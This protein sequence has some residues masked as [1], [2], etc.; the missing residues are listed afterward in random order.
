MDRIRRDSELIIRLQQWRSP[1]RDGFFRVVSLF[2]DEP[3]FTLG[4]PII[5]WSV[6]ARPLL[7]VILSWCATFYLGHALKDLCRLPRPFS[8]DR[9]VACLEDHFSAEFGLPSTH[10]QAVCAIP[11]TV[12]LSQPL[13]NLAGWILFAFVYA[14]L[15][16]FSRV[17][18][19][20][21]SL[22]D[23]LAGALLGLVTCCVVIL[24]GPSLLG[25]FYS[26]SPLVAA[27]MVLAVHLA[28]VLIY[29]ALPGL[30]TTYRDTC[31]ILGVSL[32]VWWAA[33]S[34]AFFF[35]HISLAGS[36]AVSLAV[37]VARVIFGLSVVVVGHMA[38]RKAARWSMG[39]LYEVMY[40]PPKM[41]LDQ[42]MPFVALLK[43]FSYI[44][45]GFNALG[46]VPPLFYFVGLE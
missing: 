19:G 12:L 44:G 38:V 25:A 21:H 34:T 13:P 39:K 10:A 9:R 24:A 1:A 43:F 18:L 40:G 4:L 32:G 5:G 35:S 36:H 6:T 30:S 16:C 33:L 37:W 2:G 42:H 29:P 7:L 8:V 26:L 3:A 31:A 27:P 14:S 28:L 11:L 20:V 15:V 17:Y 23:V 41:N 46:I 22:L 45:I